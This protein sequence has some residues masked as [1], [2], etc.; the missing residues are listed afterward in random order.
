MRIYKLHGSVN[1]LT[2]DDTVRRR[3]GYSL[4]SASRAVVYPAE[5][6]YFQTQYGIYEVLMRRFRDRLRVWF[7]NSP[8]L[9]FSYLWLPCI[10]IADP[11][12][13]EYNTFDDE[14]LKHP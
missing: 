4:G 12:G 1:W 2:D 10:P 7:L 3:P 11:E 8:T 13:V 6:K 5:Q 14:P 9:R